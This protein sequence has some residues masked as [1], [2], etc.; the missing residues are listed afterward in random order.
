LVGATGQASPAEAGARVGAGT[1]VEQAPASYSPGTIFLACGRDGYVGLTRVEDGRLDVAAAFD[2][3][4][5]RQA[6][7]PGLL[8]ARIL[9][10]V[11]WPAVERLEAFPWR[12]TL[13]LTRRARRLAGERLFVVGDAAG[14]VEPF[15]GEGMAWALA[16][17]VA[18]APLAAAPWRPELAGRWAQTHRRVVGRRQRICRVVAQGLRHPG[19]V[20]TALALLARWPALAGPLVRHLN[21]PAC[22]GKGSFA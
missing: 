4:A 1:L 2:T 17:A 22:N 10:D 3:V 8:A 16:A 15:T 19:L 20:R 21:T 18:V 12:G 14:Y 9:R 5:V 11:G 13:P 6:G 7:G